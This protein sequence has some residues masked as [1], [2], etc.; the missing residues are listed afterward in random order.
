MIRRRILVLLILLSVCTANAQTTYKKAADALIK[1]IIPKQAGQINTEII[2]AEQGKDVF[3]ISTKNGRILL[4]GNNS[5]AIAS[6]LNWYLKYTCNAHLS[7]NGDQMNLPARLPLPHKKEHIIIQPDYRVMFNY[8]T[9]SYSMVWWDW[10]RWEREIDFMAMNGINMPLSV[11]GLEGVWYNSLLRMGYT[12]EQAREFLVGPAYMAWQWMT[13]IESWGGPLPKSW[14]DSHV[15][16]GKKIIDREIALGMKPIQQGFSGYVPRLFKEKI[17]TAKIQYKPSWCNFEPCAQ[18]DPLDPLFEKFGTIFLEEQ[19]KLFGSYGYYAADPFHESEPPQKDSTYL[20]AVGKTISGLF[21]AFDPKGIWVMQSWS[22]RKEIAKAVPQNKLLILDINGK[23]Y[24]T[25]ENFWGYPFVVGNLH[26]F[27]NRIN[28]HGDLQL[29]ASNQFSKIKQEAPNAVGSG[30]FMEGILQNPLYYDLAFEMPFH[31]DSVDLQDWLTQYARRRYGNT[32]E[33]AA[34]AMQLLLATAYSKGTNDVENSSIIA[35]RPALDVKKSGPNAGFNIPYQPME[36]EKALQLLLADPK[37][38]H[39]DGYRFD[40]VDIQRQVLSNLGQK[41]Q[42]KA[43]KAFKDGD[44]AAFDKQSKRFLDLLKDAD[45]VTSTR[46]ELSFDKWITD[47]HSWANNPAEKAL[48]DFNASMLLTEWGPA[49]KREAEIF[50]YSWRE[51]GGLINGYYLPRWQMFFDMLRQRL[52]NNTKYNETG[53]KQVYGR[54]ALR[55]N[56]FYSSLADWEL[57]WI[58]TI[59]H[60]KKLVKGEELK[61]VTAMQ[62]KYAPL[63]K[64]YY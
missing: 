18:L 23:S 39:S 52:V 4:S 16:L 9:F 5:I 8:C 20:N 54:E 60:P 46:P 49:G 48:Y 3:E 43:A 14:I 59:K 50:D 10:K 31:K 51:W 38:Q 41:I 26:N 15:V 63:L 24:K 42:Q 45:A 22:I 40:I 12:D 36:L 6:A 56:S 64:E 35:A 33:N 61:T 21:T 55:A 32:S 62:K 47:A 7:W 1:R 34:E 29:V 58:K 57:N 25:K 53:L 19:K 30:L 28:L 37:L 13:N 17:P 2:S 11:V 44:L 27:G